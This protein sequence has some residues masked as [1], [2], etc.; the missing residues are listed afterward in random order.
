[1]ETSLKVGYTYSTFGNIAETSPFAM[2][3]LHILFIVL[4]VGLLTLPVLA[5]SSDSGV[6][7][8]TDVATDIT[9]ESAVHARDQAVKQGQRAAFEQL[10]QR[11]GADPALGAKLGDDD[12]AAL[13]QSFEVQ[14]ERSSPVRYI[15]IFTV[16]FRP[17]AVRSF[18]AGRNAAYFDTASA[19]VLIL[20]VTLTAG[21][22]ILWEETTPWRQAWDSIAHGGGLVPIILPSGALDDIA[23]LS[24][25]E[26]MDGKP[27]SLAGLINKYQAGGALVAVLDG[28]LSKPGSTLT[29][30][31]RRYDANGTSLSTTSVILSV[32]TDKKDLDALLPQA[33]KQVRE[34]LEADWRQQQ[35][36][37][38]PVAANPTEGA[39]PDNGAVAHLPVNVPIATLAEWEQIRQKLEHVPNV[40][41]ADIITLAR[42]MTSIEIEFNG[43]IAQLQSALTAQG[44]ILSQDTS[45]GT[46]LLQPNTPTS[47]P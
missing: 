8:I 5:Q 39:V 32:P 31:M 23:L 33:A 12:I 40:R 13:V 47:T 26:A 43:D 17:S 16:Q 29:V 34:Q 14:N 25:E 45:N 3:L 18:L 37:Q 2:R 22:P 24:T 44:L 38:A 42:G 7:E 1:M 15:G 41:H 4:G 21:H 35:Q 30:D 19:P 10:L 6:Y 27:D 36:G 11:L 28:D 9:A 20:P 46:W